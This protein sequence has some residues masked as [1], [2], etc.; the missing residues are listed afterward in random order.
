LGRYEKREEENEEKVKEKRKRR[1]QWH[2]KNKIYAE[3]QKGFMKS[4]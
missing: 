3:R 1:G 4:W 2:E